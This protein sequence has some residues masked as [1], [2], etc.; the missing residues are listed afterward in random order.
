M[1]SEGIYKGPHSFPQNFFWRILRG[2]GGLLSF[3]VN[4][5]VYDFCLFTLTL[6]VAQKCTL[7]TSLSEFISVFKQPTLSV[8]FSY[9][10]LRFSV[11]VLVLQTV[12]MSSS[13]SNVPNVKKPY[14]SIPGSSA[15][16]SRSIT[17]HACWSAC[18]VVR[19]WFGSSSI[20]IVDHLQFQWFRPFTWRVVRVHERLHH[21]VR[22]QL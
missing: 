5:R 19:F 1:W 9:S 3:G 14:H 17:C 18:Y 12:K 6:V 21:W 4:L 10:L 22:G 20:A 7:I 8:V 11:I 16:S 13:S 2:R 15:F